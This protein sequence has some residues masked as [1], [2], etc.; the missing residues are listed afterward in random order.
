MTES[1]QNSEMFIVNAK[2][3]LDFPVY[4]EFSAHEEECFF[5]FQKQLQR[6]LSFNS[7]HSEIRTLFASINVCIPQKTPLR[8]LELSNWCTGERGW[9]LRSKSTEIQEMRYKL[10]LKK[11]KGNFDYCNFV[12]NCSIWKKKKK[13]PKT[14]Q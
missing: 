12:E 8:K 9:V 10:C 1:F 13:Q 11:I 7:K 14:R 2:P 4:N 6:N 5:G 3:K